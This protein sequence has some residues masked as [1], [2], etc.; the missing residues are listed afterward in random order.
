M[1][2]KIMLQRESKANK[3]EIS[4]VSDKGRDVSPFLTQVRKVKKYKYICHTYEKNKI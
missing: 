1:Q 4:L 3:Y 2:L